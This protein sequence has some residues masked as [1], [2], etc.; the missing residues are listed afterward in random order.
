MRPWRDYNFSWVFIEIVKQVEPNRDY[1]LAPAPKSRLR[2]SWYF[3][4]LFAAGTIAVALSLGWH[5]TQSNAMVREA[6]RIQ[7]R[8]A[9]EKDVL[10]RRWNA[11][12]GG[13]YAK[14]SPSTQPNPY[15]KVP[16]RD[17]STPAGKQL[18]LI[19]PAYM[20]R[21][22]HELGASGTGVKGHITSLKPIRPQ[23]APDA[24]E[25]RALRSFDQGAKEASVELEVD[26]DRY[27]RLMRPLITEKDCLGCHAEQGYKEGQVRGG[28]SVSV[29]LAP[30]MASARRSQRWLLVGHIVVWVAGMGMLLVWAQHLTG[31]LRERRR[32]AKA[33]ERLAVTDSLTGANNR[34]F[35]MRRGREEFLR[36]QRYGSPLSMMMIDIDHFKKVN[37]THGHQMGDEVLKELVRVCQGAMRQTDIFGR[38]GGEEFAVLLTNTNAENALRAAENL[39]AMLAE[40][41]VPADQGP[42]SVTVSIGVSGLASTD[43]SLDDLILRADQ[44]L[45]QAKESGRNR[46]ALAR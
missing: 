8:T 2:V 35:W 22:V 18:T 13:V 42:L 7:A 39:R 11:Q 17:I 31:R 27:M 1:L 15:L 16:E 9:F 6:A 32:M 34:R 43:N 4:V 3:W 30:L 14:I 19:N 26:G 28:I 12:Y 24:W 21:Q 37:D 10:Y 40:L 44:A 36:S 33:M 41:K 20:T 5:L 25:T 45:Y 29:P 38:Y 23:N 46:V